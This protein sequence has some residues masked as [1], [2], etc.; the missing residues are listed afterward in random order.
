[1]QIIIIFNFSKHH[2]VRLIVYLIMLVFT[3]KWFSI[4]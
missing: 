2:Y 3:L 4:C 1:M